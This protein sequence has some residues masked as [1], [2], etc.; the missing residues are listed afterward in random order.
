MIGEEPDDIL[1]PELKFEPVNFATLAALRFLA[2]AGVDI[3]N[4]ETYSFESVFGGLKLVM[5]K[6]TT[7]TRG[8][9]KGQKKY[10]SR[11]DCLE[12]FINPEQISAEKEIFRKETGYC[13]EC[14]GNGLT[15][16]GWTKDVG[17]YYRVCEVCGGTG[18]AI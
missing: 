2:A 13:S 10:G 7:F 3:E 5:G 18:A 9:R 1:N 11:K 16:T 4:M 8:P 15:W 6:V 14:C 12:V 17:Y